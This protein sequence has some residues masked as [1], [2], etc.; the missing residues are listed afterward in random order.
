MRKKDEGIDSLYWIDYALEVGVEHLKPLSF[1]DKGYLF[2]SDLD[3][4]FVLIV[5]VITSLILS[6][7]VAL[8]CFKCCCCSKKNKQKKD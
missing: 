4:H 6:I 8:R 1:E 5:I 7:Y 3:V 2:T